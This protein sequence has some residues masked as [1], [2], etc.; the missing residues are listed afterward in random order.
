[1]SIVLLISIGLI[2]GALYV[3]GLAAYR[4]YLAIKNLKSEVARSNTL[5]SEIQ[6]APA[7]DPLP[8]RAHG[9]SDLVATIQHRQQLKRAR[10][11]KA[12][13][14]QRRLVQRI[15]DIELD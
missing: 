2:G 9:T 1:M 10:R 8:A 11:R 5:L 15:R 13:E 6:S 3:T 14:R 7:N 12:E 4:L